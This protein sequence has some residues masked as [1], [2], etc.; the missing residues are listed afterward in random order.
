[1]GSLLHVLLK[2]KGCLLEYQKLMSSKHFQR[3]LKLRHQFP[4]ILMSYEITQKFF[5]FLQLY[6]NIN[7]Q[8]FSK[9]FT[10][11]Y[12]FLFCS[13]WNMLHTTVCVRELL[14]NMSV[15][16]NTWNATTALVKGLLSF[17]GFNYDITSVVFIQWHPPHSSVVQ[18]YPVIDPDTETITLRI[19]WNRA[20]TDAKDQ[21][22][23][24]KH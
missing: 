13:P 22:Q 24:D 1:M 10:L 15:Y 17:G 18:W 4:T 12:A 6:E 23:T 21:R 14:L 20:C 19:Y 3:K 8:V 7:F 9:V 5:F 11:K 2:L 16:F